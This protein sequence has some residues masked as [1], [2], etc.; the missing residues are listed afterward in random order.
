MAVSA[1]LLVCCSHPHT[2][3]PSCSLSSCRSSSSTTK[4]APPPQRKGA[5]SQHVRQ[6]RATNWRPR[7]P[8]APSLH[9]YTPSR[10][11]PGWLGFATPVPPCR[12]RPPSQLCAGAAARV[13]QAPRSCSS[14]ALTHSSTS[15]RAMLPLP[16][17][18]PSPRA[19]RARPSAHADGGGAGSPAC[20]HAARVAGQCVR[21]RVLAPACTGHLCAHTTRLLAALRKL[22]HAT[23]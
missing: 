11:T 21:V 18:P 23:Q 14:T 13:S 3:T 2:T 4:G 7:L 5:T 22:T 15:P 17:P 16:L 1:R 9:R 10:C 12:A 19:T 8:N 6:K 20:V